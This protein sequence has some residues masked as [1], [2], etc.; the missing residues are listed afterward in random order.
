MS[1]GKDGFCGLR[2]KPLWDKWLG[3]PGGRGGNQ[4]AA[5]ADLASVEGKIDGYDRPS[6]VPGSRVRRPAEPGGER[7]I[8]RKEGRRCRRSSR[9]SCAPP[10]Q[11]RRG[12]SA[13]RLDSIQEGVVAAIWRFV[14]ANGHTTAAEAAFSVAATPC[15][16]GFRSSKLRADGTRSVPAT[17][18]ALPGRAD[19]CVTAGRGSLQ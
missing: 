4:G 19:S 7:E 2:C 16:A 13:N 3:A 1:I 15:G 9:Q 11:V 6:M 5:P 14:K 8:Q 17:L 12:R 10:G 18:R